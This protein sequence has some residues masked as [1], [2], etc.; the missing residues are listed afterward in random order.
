MWKT[1]SETELESKRKGSLESFTLQKRKSVY[2]WMAMGLFMSVIATVTTTF[3]SKLYHDIK[4]IDWS[5]SISTFFG[6]LLFFNTVF[7]SYW[8]YGYRKFSNLDDADKLTEYKDYL[9]KM[10]KKIC[11]KCNR[12]YANNTSG[13]DMCKRTLIG[14]ST[15]EWVDD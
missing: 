7:L 13:C 9:I 4:T 11:V 2:T 15:C 10:E 3:P 5:L 6:F 8:F 1:L 12:I 14:S